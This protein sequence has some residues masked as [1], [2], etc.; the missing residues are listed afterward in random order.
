MSSG[1]NHANIS[2]FDDSPSAESRVPDDILV[3][4]L[5]CDALRTLTVRLFLE[6]DGTSNPDVRLTVTPRYTLLGKV[7]KLRLMPFR[8]NGPGAST[9]RPSLSAPEPLVPGRN[10]FP[11]EDA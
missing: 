1:Y 5:R 11:V 10:P 4:A 6:E 9:R 3:R 2:F 7:L 8:R